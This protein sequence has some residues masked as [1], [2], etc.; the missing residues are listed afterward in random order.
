MYFIS[1]FGYNDQEKIIY[2]HF[3]DRTE[4]KYLFCP[5]TTDGIVV[6]TLS[7]I[8]LPWLIKLSTNDNFDDIIT[9]CFC[10]YDNKYNKFRR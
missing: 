1:V 2:T 3:V 8:N 9:T 10:R 4:T 5:V 7:K 6:S